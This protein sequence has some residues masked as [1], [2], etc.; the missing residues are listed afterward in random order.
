MANLNRVIMVGRLTR[1]PEIRNTPSGTPVAKFGIA[2]NRRPNKQGENVADFFNVTAWSKLAELCQQYIS[3]GSLVA[4][5]GR[6]QSSS[7]ETA[8]GQKRSAVEIVADNVQFLSRSTG[9]SD[10]YAQPANQG[11]NRDAQPVSVESADSSDDLPD[12]D[13]PF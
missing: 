5:E 2:V 13:I 6:L 7:W 11:Q 4:I 1:D 8:E 3:K 9:A 12:D 10:S